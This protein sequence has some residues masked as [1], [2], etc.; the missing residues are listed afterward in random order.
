M[1][2]FRTISFKNYKAIENLTIDCGDFQWTVLLGNNNTGKTSLLKAIA[3]LHPFDIMDEKTNKITKIP[4]C[5]YL[6]INQTC[7]V[8]SELD[9][10]HRW[11]YTF[12][13]G[14]DYV[15]ISKDYKNDLKDFHLFAYGVSRYPSNTSLAEQQN[16]DCDTLFFH[17]K[18]L[19]NIEE[20][21]MQLDYAA[22]KE[23]AARERLEKIKNLICGNIFPEILDVK[24][25]S[26]DFKNYVLFKTLDGWFKYNE[27]G[28][29]YQSM[30]S[31]VVD[32]GKRLFEK[33]PNSENPFNESAV[34]LVDEIDLHLHPEWQRKVIATVSRVFPNV[35]FIATTHSPLVIQSMENV[36][37]Y[38]LR[39][40]GEKIVA[41]HPE[42][43]NFSGW[44]VEEILRDLMKLDDNIRSDVYQKKYKDF[45]D[46]LDAN[47][48]EKAKAAYETL[49]QILHPESSSRRILEMQL[50]LLLED[51]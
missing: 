9:N 29:G 32:L 43:T 5:H 26:K 28:F 47:D 42:I 41:D 22:S 17:D 31:W 4:S 2:K 12:T 30:L 36:N 6:D 16:G 8:W 37:L 24:F 15:S 11:A 49:I 46:S 19:V 20:W 40:E 3:A 39:R 10:R 18:K 25:E 13:Y 38:V 7:E 48:K 35:Q 14:S 1:E 50:E 33:Y 23:P 34:V 44:T 45:T 21:L 27:L 51:D